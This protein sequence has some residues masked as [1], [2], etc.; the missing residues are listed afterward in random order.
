MAK[1]K[2]AQVGRDALKAALTDNAIKEFGESNVLSSEDLLNSIQGIPLDGN[3]PMQF[4]LGLDIITLSR[5]MSL[6]GDFGS[7]KSLMSWYFAKKFLESGGLVVFIDAERK[8][9]PD[10][11]RAVVDNDELFNNY[12]S[13]YPVIHL[14]G[15]LSRITQS[16]EDYRNMCPNQDI[17]YM[18]LVDS[19]A[20]V[21]SEE[22]LKAMEKDGLASNVGYGAAHNA[23]MITEQMRA[24][25]P[26]LIANN[27]ITLLTI[28]HQKE[29]MDQPASSFMPKKK[30]EPGGVHKDFA[31]TYIL[32]FAKGKNPKSVT[33]DQMQF[34]IKTKKSG[35]S[36]T[37]RK[38]QVYMHSITENNRLRTHLNWDKSL[39]DLL[40]DGDQVS[41]TRVK[42]ELGFTKVGSK[43]S[44]KLL[45]FKDLSAE[46]AGNKL[47]N[48]PVAV[49]KIQSILGI[50]RKRPF[51]GEIAPSLIEEAHT[52]ITVTKGE[53]EASEAEE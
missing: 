11:F 8:S 7:G 38:I 14:E 19:I 18:I 40:A 44:C 50:V 36:K 13:V 53:E 47:H 5:I 26:D 20:A 24:L 41:Q 22:A 1:K 46:E 21:T 12:V 3:L 43:V 28:N 29:S 42:D 10:Q 23:R 25:V 30:G 52:D 2:P 27:P 4:L 31:N 35:F 16:V 48:D 32:E 37:G 15:M 34:H 45:G 17:P 9:N 51:G 33:E 39:V 49:Q 6:V